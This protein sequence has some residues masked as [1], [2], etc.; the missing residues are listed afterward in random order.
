[1]SNREPNLTLCKESLQR[2]LPPPP[3][4]TLAAIPHLLPI[5]N[6]QDLRIRWSTS[7]HQGA[8]WKGLFDFLTESL[9]RSH[10]IPL[11]RLLV[12]HILRLI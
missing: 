9:A 11:V 8:R 10:Q 4:R 1:M 12:V 2:A 3:I 6:Q 7:L 5:F